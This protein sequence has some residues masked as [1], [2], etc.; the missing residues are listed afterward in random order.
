M[1]SFNSLVVKQVSGSF[2]EG[3]FQKEHLTEIFAS[4]KS[5]FPLHGSGGK[6]TSYVFFQETV[7][8]FLTIGYGESENFGIIAVEYWDFFHSVIATS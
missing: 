7:Q 5:H 8:D 6:G 1:E 3:L 4:G 2:K